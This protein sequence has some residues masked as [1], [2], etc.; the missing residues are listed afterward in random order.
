MIQM[1]KLNAGN[2]QVVSWQ[3]CMKSPNL[4]KK[5]LAISMDLIEKKMKQW[6]KQKRKREEKKKK[7]RRQSWVWKKKDVLGRG[8]YEQIH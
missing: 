4:A 1:C 5:L 8:E 6:K 2:I 3:V 7:K